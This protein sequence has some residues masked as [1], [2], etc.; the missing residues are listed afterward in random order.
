[1]GGVDKKANPRL[2]AARRGLAQRLRDLRRSRG[3]RLSDIT[4]ISGVSEPYLS[5]IE[6]GERW[7][8]L[9]TLLT[10]AS[11]YGVD[12]SVLLKETSSPDRVALHR[13]GAV[14]SG[15]EAAGSGTMGHGGFEVGYDLGSR[16]SSSDDRDEPGAGGLSSPEEMLGM[17]F[18]G[19]FSMSLA[20]QLGAAGFTPRRIATT[21][22]VRL[23]S[24]PDKIEISEVVLTCEAD[25]GGIVAARFEEIANITKRSCVVSRAL[26]AVSVSLDARLTPT[27]PG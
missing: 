15:D 12:P 14:W 27:A 18:A 24:S 7:P 8:S 17:A 5:R 16:L 20:E 26:A 1:M 10:L 9:P 3:L 21:A 19:C 25:V 22:E 6:S 2:A 23:A 4:A 11:A 13:A